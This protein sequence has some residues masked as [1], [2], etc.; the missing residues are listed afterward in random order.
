MALHTRR[1]RIIGAA[2]ALALVSAFVGPHAH[3]AQAQDGG[4][5]DIVCGAILDGTFTDSFEHGYRIVLPVGAILNVD[6]V[7]NAPQNDV[8]FFV[9][10][11]A[12]EPTLTQDGVIS[13]SPITGAYTAAQR[14]PGSDIYLIQVFDNNYTSGSYTVSVGCELPDGTIIEP[15]DRAQ[16]IDP[17]EYDALYEAEIEAQAAAGASSVADFSGYGFPGLDAV[18][19]EAAIN[20]PLVFDAPNTGSL[21]ADGGTPYAYTFSASAGD[22]LD[23]S[24]ARLSGNLNLALAVVHDQNTVVFYSGMVA[25]GTLFMRF[26]LPLDGDYTIG[27]YAPNLLPP[28]DPAATVFQLQVTLNP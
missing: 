4:N 27:V 18:S 16:V 25:E 23:L 24:F 20:V 17:A 7:E 5:Q 2:L 21:A 10:N 22:A 28:D 11:Y 9:Y 12:G 19:F 26:T 3:P 13:G 1:A 15:G 6:V 8:R 14:L